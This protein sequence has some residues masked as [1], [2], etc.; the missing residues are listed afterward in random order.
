MATNCPRATAI[1]AS[2]DVEERA[3]QQQPT[4]RVL[5]ADQ[6]L[7]ADDAGVGEVH[8]RLEVHDELVLGQG[9]RE[10]VL[11]VGGRTGGHVGVKTSVRLRPDA[12]AR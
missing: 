5:P 6:R 8:D 11:Q 12:L 9:D 10:L 7:V 4:L 3:R 2:L 1:P